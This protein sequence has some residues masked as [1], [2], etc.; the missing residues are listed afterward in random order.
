MNVQ[1]SELVKYDIND[2]ICEFVEKMNSNTEIIRSELVWIKNQ[3]D[4][5]DKRLDR[6]S[7][8]SSPVVKTIEEDIKE[9]KSELNELKSKMK[10]EFKN[11]EIDA[12]DN[13]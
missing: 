3:L 7:S 2:T 13:R 1:R 5:T 6:L 11:K 12:R 10:S 4:L 9:L 8:E